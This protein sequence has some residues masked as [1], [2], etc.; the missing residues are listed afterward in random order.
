MKVRKQFEV[1]S[2]MRSKVVSDEDMFVPEMSLPIENILQQF[3]FVENLRLSEYAQHGFE[4][5]DT[6]EDD[7]DIEE[8]DNLDLAEKHE[9]YERASAVIDK[10]N[11]EME[12]QKRVIEQ[13]KEKEPQ[14]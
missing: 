7:F 9:L 12:R 1:I 2:V 3:A 6:N 11:A 13:E 14:E 8:F 4:H 10:Y 5:A